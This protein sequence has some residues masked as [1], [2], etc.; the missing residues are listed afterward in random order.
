LEIVEELLNKYNKIK[1]K[2]V[3][4]IENF[5]SIFLKKEIHGAIINF[6]RKLSLAV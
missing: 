2:I 1:E 6:E 5:P 4:R 3:G